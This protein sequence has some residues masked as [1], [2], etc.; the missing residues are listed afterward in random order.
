MGSVCATIQLS[1]GDIEGIA[2]ETGCTYFKFSVLFIK[3]QPVIL[4]VF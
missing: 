2:N 3:C 1:E 4:W